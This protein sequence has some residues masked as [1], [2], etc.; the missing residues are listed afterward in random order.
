MSQVKPSDEHYALARDILFWE[1]RAVPATP[2]EG[3]VIELLAYL[4]KYR[5]YDLSAYV[6]QIDDGRL[7]APRLSFEFP[8][9]HTNMLVDFRLA[10]DSKE[11]TPAIKAMIRGVRATPWLG[12]FSD[13]QIVLG[14]SWL[15]DRD[16]ARF[17]KDTEI[18][19]K[20]E[21]LPVLT[22]N[23]DKRFGDAALDGRF[24]AL[25]GS[26]GSEEIAR[27]RLVTD[28][29]VGVN[30]VGGYNTFTTMLDARS[31]HVVKI[32]TY[33]AKTI[34]SPD[35]LDV[36]LDE[37]PNVPLRILC[38]GPTTNVALSEGSDPKTLA[39][40]L[41]EG[42]QGLRLVL[43]QRRSEG[44]PEVD[45]ELR[46]YGDRE[47][48]SY[49]RGAIL[50]DEGKQSVETV[51]ASAWFF[52]ASRANYGEVLRLDGNSNLASLMN[53][54]FDRAW[55]NSIPLP[56][57]SWKKPILWA[58]GV[59]SPETIGA[60]VIV[61]G[62]LIILAIKPEWAGDVVVGLLAVAMVITVGMWQ[63]GQRM[64]RVMEFQKELR[65]AETRRKQRL[66]GVL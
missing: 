39:D 57:R 20:L 34:F 47:D 55:D 28:L 13:R 29:G 23:R 44:K 10:L 14:V 30:V 52:G 58:L 24:G 56:M 54:Y 36:W 37:R 42:I 35:N 1:K 8:Q 27:S 41:V 50:Y 51:L 63:I 65:D 25:M 61:V 5:F 43:K 62:S 6:P 31:G 2:D 46:I 26:L 4:L 60:G 15:L 18:V 17:E 3:T 21:P 7:V 19:P 32:G 38:L 45:V 53:N 49:F 11:Y 9:G 33:H 22:L 59:L 48:D 40:S 16:L 12:S 64:R 66:A